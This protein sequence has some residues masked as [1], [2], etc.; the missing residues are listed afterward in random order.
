MELAHERTITDYRGEGPV[1]EPEYW[2]HPRYGKSHRGY[3]VVG[4]SWYEAV[5]YANWLNEQSKVEGFKLQVW[6]GG[7]LET[8]NLQPGTLSA[9]LPSS[10][11]WERIAGGIASAERYPWDPPRGQPRARRRQYEPEPIPTSR[12]SAVRRRWACIR[13]AS[14]SRSG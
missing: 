6:R 7:H 11:E 3:P 1:T 14:V 13:S 2:R 8:C 4:V 9:R 12:A 10:D 5:A